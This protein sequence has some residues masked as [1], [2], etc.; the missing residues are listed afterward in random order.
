MCPRFNYSL[1]VGF[2]K[3]TIFYLQ[4]RVFGK[5]V[6]RYETSRIPT[7]SVSDPCECVCSH[8]CCSSE[9]YRV[10]AAILSWLSSVYKVYCQNTIYNFN[11]ITI[12]SWRALSS[13]HKASLK[14]ITICNGCVGT[15]ASRGISNHCRRSWWKWSVPSKRKTPYHG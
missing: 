6:S 8:R 7:Y 11:N 13:L 2:N 14:H 5:T 15:E 10:R 3:A 1:Q 4:I 12:Y 9:L